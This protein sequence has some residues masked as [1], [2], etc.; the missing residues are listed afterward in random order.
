MRRILKKMKAAYY[1]VA[2][3]IISLILGG[4][5]IALLGFDPLTA[6]KGMLKGSV[7]SISAFCVSLNKSVP[8]I[9]TGLAFAV[10][11]RSGLVN[12]GAE[13]QLYIGAMSAVLVG[14][15]IE[16]HPALHL[17]LVLLVGFISGALYGTIV[18]VLKNRFDANELIVT[19]MLNYIAI[20][21]VEWLIDEPFRGP[22][23]QG[24]FPQS[25]TIL[26][27]AKLPKLFEGV[28]LHAGVIV[29]IIA[30]LVYWFFLWKTTKGYEMRVV[31]LNPSAAAYAGMDIGKNRI[32]A[33][34]LAGGF[35]G[36]A[37]AVE[38]CAVQFKIIYGFSSNFGF[39]GIA[40]ALLGNG[41]PIGILLSGLLLGMLRAGADKMQVLTSVPSS[42]LQVIQG[43]IILFV[44]GRKLFNISRLKKKRQQNKVEGK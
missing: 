2:A 40:V 19:I 43:M 8:I 1:P 37:G 20:S 13:G 6:Y 24:N 26:D 34:F 10:A 12:L 5:L 15:Y 30:L 31:G 38:L 41:T 7:G 36:L 44:V 18:A 22:S 4:V 9:L 3:I 17:S 39:D 11:N 28:R 14:A 35:A 33:M 16:M 42:T 32:R 29:V 21:F 27:S 25:A 23:T